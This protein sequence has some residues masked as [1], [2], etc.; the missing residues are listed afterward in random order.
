MP[1]ENIT[2]K[3]DGRGGARPGAGRPP[4]LTKLRNMSDIDAVTLA[5]AFDLRVALIRSALNGDVHALRHLDERLHGQLRKATPI[6]DRLDVILAA[7]P[8]DFDA[9]ALLA[10]A[11]ERLGGGGGN[12]REWTTAEAQR[13]GQVG[14]GTLETLAA[15]GDKQSATTLAKLLMPDPILTLGEQLPMMTPDQLRETM[16]R[17]YAA[18]WPWLE[19][20]EVERMVNAICKPR[21]GDDGEV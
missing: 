5:S 20:E 8:A 15:R 19:R 7:L 12:V 3:K 1:E 21:G 16:T 9:E 10:D 13:V 4:G 17:R 6:V 18:A 11:H 14:L 2:P